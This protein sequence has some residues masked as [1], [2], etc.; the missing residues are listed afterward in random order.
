MDFVDNKTRLWNFNSCVESDYV[1][2]IKEA[3]RLAPAKSKFSFVLCAPDDGNSA[4]CSVT[5]SYSDKLSM[6]YDISCTRDTLNSDMEIQQIEALLQTMLHCDKVLV[7]EELEAFRSSYT[8]IPINNKEVDRDAMDLLSLL[9]LSCPW[10]ISIQ[11]G[12]YSGKLRVDHNEIY[13]DCVNLKLISP[14]VDKLIDL[15]LHIHP[16]NFV[17][18]ELPESLFETLILNGVTK[19][20]GKCRSTI[21]GKAFVI[22][23]NGMTLV[24]DTVTK[25]RLLE[26]SKRLPEKGSIA[27]HRRLVESL[28]MYLAR[29]EDC[30]YSEHIA[31]M[32]TS[33]QLDQKVLQRLEHFLST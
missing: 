7:T 5:I 3:H 4:S 25:E 31:D 32:L 15:M 12:D 20:C 28:D 22:I 13:L 27:L 33:M 23:G 14:D 19:V 8:V 11:C 10:Q 2:L 6:S 16:I 9:I 30:E 21:I 1:S 17:Q 26:L 18:V 24:S 29:F